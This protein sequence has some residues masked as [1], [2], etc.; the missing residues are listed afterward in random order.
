MLTGS[1]VVRYICEW[2][3]CGLENIRGAGGEEYR[4]MTLPELDLDSLR[5]M[6]KKFCVSMNTRRIPKL[7]GVTDGKAVGTSIEHGFKDYLAES[8]I[9]ESGSSASGLDLPSPALNTDI[10]T[11]RST[12]PQ[13]SCP[14]KNA[15]QKIYGLG[16]NILVFVYDKTDF[17]H[18][19]GGYAVLRFVSCAFISKERTGDYQLTTE[20]L[21]ILENGGSNRD[22]LFALFEDKN[23]PGDDITHTQLAE[24]VLRNPPVQGYLTISNALQWRLQY[25]RVVDMSTTDGLYKII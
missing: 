14:Y 16:Y 21:R 25:Q 2:W 18:E 13:S 19:N 22:D 24:E 23:L 6:A 11:T 12:Q 3:N 9:F 15:R 5:S 10:K 4:E 1:M 17:A 7:Y 8:Y 20:I